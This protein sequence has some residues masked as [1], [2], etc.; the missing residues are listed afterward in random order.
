MLEANPRIRHLLRP[1]EEGHQG[2]PVQ[3]WSGVPRDE[4]GRLLQ[5]QGLLWE[6]HLQHRDRQPRHLRL[7]HV[8]G[9]GAPRRD[10]HGVRIGHVHMGHG[11]VRERPAEPVW[12]VRLWRRRCRGVPEVHERRLEIEDRRRGLLA[13]GKLRV[14]VCVCVKFIVNVTIAVHTVDLVTVCVRVCVSE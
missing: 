9:S 4:G 3:P 5:K 13:N 7:Q 10:R 6:K 14:L 8:V 11:G 12:R 2:D 1:G